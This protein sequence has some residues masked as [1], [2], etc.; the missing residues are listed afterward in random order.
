MILSSCTFHSDNAVGI[1]TNSCSVKLKQEL[2]ILLSRNIKRFSSIAVNFFFP[3]K[4]IDLFIVKLS[5]YRSVIEAGLKFPTKF[6]KRKM[7]V[8]S[9]LAVLIVVVVC[10]SAR[11]PKQ[12]ENY[13]EF[14]INEEDEQGY[15]EEQQTK[16]Y[17]QNP[18]FSF[19]ED[20]YNPYPEFHQQEQQMGSQVDNSYNQPQKDP[21][22]HGNYQ[23]MNYNQQM[24]INQQQQEQQMIPQ[25]QVTSQQQIN[26]QQQQMMSHQGIP[27][28]QMTQQQQMTAQQQVIPQDLM[29]PQQQMIPQEQM[30]MQPNP[31]MQS[32]F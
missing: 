19:P 1:Y 17:Y 14:Q 24:S 7:K 6:N 30:S 4:A 21:Q 20:S 16:Q 3:L 22:N 5:L 9:L 15:G 13:P 10:D 28:Q 26:H 27:Q 8:A 31:E 12:Y 2:E 11:I 23:Q 32:E 18:D 25:Q 29:N